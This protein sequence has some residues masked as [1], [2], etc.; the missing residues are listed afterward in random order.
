MD[1]KKVWNW[2][3]KSSADPQRLSLTIR[4][5]VPALVWF[6]MVS[7]NGNVDV[8]AFNE[9]ADKLADFAAIGVQFGLSAV[10]LFGVVRKLWLSFKPAV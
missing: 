9:V 1:I 6:F 10:A 7:G 5:G 4:A 2:L 3:V 8:N